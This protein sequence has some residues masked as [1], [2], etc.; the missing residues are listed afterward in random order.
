[1]EIVIRAAVVF[2]FLFVLLR[3]MGKRELAELSTFELVVIIVMG[4][5]VQQGVTEEDMSITGAVLAVSTMALLTMVLS[6]IT[7]RSRR[8]RPALEGVPVVL[9]RNGHVHDEV[10]RYEGMPV[11][12]LLQAARQEGI[13]DLAHVAV[14]VL[15]ADGRLSFIR[16]NGDDQEGSSTGSQAPVAET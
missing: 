5:L 16:T 1:M 11:D 15:E 14:C 3:G 12:E 4:D 7:F 9:V 10:L 8:L 2:A 13:S 6:S